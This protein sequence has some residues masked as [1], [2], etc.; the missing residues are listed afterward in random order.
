[1]KPHIGSG[2]RYKAVELLPFCKSATAV[3]GLR[4][5]PH[6]G[7]YLELPPDCIGDL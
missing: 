3:V 5:M 4:F 1:M 7:I 6:A 2:M